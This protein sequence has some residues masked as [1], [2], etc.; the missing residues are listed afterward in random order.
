MRRVLGFCVL[1]VALALS[2]M[3]PP[4]AT[5]GGIVLT[6]EQPRLTSSTAALLTGTASGT[7]LVRIDVWAADRWKIENSSVPVVAGRYDT[8]VPAPDS[9]TRYR[10]AAGMVRTEEVL[11][12]SA[13]AP[14]PEPEPEPEPDPSP[15]R[16]PDPLTTAVR[17]GR[18]PTAPAGPAPWPRTSPAPS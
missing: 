2:F 15:A 12:Q 4:S 5:A 18:R 13:P 9:P 16:S 8:A 3:A 10:V 7:N 1:M 11:I 14:A 6:L 17:A